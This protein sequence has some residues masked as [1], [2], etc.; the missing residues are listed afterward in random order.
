MAAARHRGGH[1]AAPYSS[2]SS[3]C[4]PWGGCAC[5][6]GGAW[7]WPGGADDEGAVQPRRRAPG[8]AEAGVVARDEH[9]P[10][11]R[12]PAA[13]LRRRRGPRGG[14]LRR[15]VERRL[16]R[17]ERGRARA[18]PRRSQRD[19]AERRRAP[20]QGFAPNSGLESCRGGRFPPDVVE[21]GGIG[22][23]CGCKLAQ[24]RRGE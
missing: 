24:C 17:P 8:P 3:S 9:A 18:H 12:R 7:G 4:F 20:T 22:W 2:S 23:A 11:R 16:L 21:L 6:G 13:F 10:Q 15:G 5:R 1:H 14:P 19:R